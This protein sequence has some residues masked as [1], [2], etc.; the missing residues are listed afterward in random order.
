[1]DL[2]LG[3]LADFASI[4]HEGKLNILGIF[5]EINPAVL[6]I[7]LPIFYV[8]VSYSAGPTEFDT[9]KTLGIA[10]QTE[11]GDILV[12]LEQA[13]HV[14]RPA[15]PGTRTKVNQVHALAGLPFERAGSYAFVL[16]VDGRPEGS[17]P[18]R[19]NTPT[20]PEGAEQ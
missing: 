7:A 6:P 8:V 12:T 3:V 9:D 16:S 13:A 15:R 5:D 18:F 19:V 10:L 20:A 1:M 2:Q 4:T 11:D 14:R 17:I